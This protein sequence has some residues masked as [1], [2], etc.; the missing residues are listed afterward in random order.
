MNLQI[1]AS[2]RWIICKALVELTSDEGQTK[3]FA[4]YP[5]I[6]VEPFAKDLKDLMDKLADA[7]PRIT[8]GN[9]E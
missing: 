2:Q 6:D 4:E 9:G 3:F 5:D 7:Q 1:S 8:E